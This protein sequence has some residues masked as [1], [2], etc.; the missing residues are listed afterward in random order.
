MYRVLRFTQ[1]GPAGEGS[2][3][4]PQSF[5]LLDWAFLPCW[6]QSCCVLLGRLQFSGSGFSFCRQLRRSF[7]CY[8][9]SKL[10]WSTV[11]NYMARVLNRLIYVCVVIEG[12]W[13]L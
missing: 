4:P 9:L 3:S 11:Q 1:P 7:L 5:P 6:P 12:V 2:P 8:L 13:L 10:G